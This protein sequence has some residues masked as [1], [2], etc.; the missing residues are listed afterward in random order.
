MATRQNLGTGNG[1]IW[2]KVQCRWVDNQSATSRHQSD[3]ITSPTTQP[4]LLIL[5]LIHHLTTL[6]SFSLCFLLLLCRLTYWINRTA[7][8]PP[9]CHF[10]VPSRSLI[11]DLFLSQ[12]LSFQLRLCA[13]NVL[14]IYSAIYNI[15]NLQSED[16]RS[17]SASS[18]SLDSRLAQPCPPQ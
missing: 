11:A 9:A 8:V 3:S 2:G 5:I 4:H 6:L 17:S 7:I 15:S 10:A 18:G 14:T 13:P 12:R 1:R 16:S